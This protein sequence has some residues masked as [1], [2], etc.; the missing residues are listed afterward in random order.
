[1][2]EHVDW[3]DSHSIMGAR[4]SV[5]MLQ[6]MSNALHRDDALLL[7]AA[8]PADLYVQPIGSP[9]PVERTKAVTVVQAL[10]PDVYV[11]TRE[12]AHRL[13]GVAEAD[14]QT[15]PLIG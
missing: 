2:L 6:A 13:L 10:A 5:A 4:R 7:L 8:L 12:Q 9:E 3:A 11:F 14:A 1:M 15:D